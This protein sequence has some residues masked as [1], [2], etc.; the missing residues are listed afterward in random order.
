LKV[1]VSWGWGQ[2]KAQNVSRIILMA[3]VG[4]Q[5]SNK[6]LVHLIFMTQNKNC[7][8]TLFT[9]PTYQLL[10]SKA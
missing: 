1:N 2:K 3:P 4:K 8:Q 5:K 7:L 6:E 9:T 10:A